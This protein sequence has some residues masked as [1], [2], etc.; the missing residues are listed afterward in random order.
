MTYPGLLKCGS[1]CILRRACR[2]LHMTGILRVTDPLMGSPAL[3]THQHTPTCSK[4]CT[5][6]HSPDA[7]SQRG[8]NVFFLY[9]SAVLWFFSR[10]R[11]H[12]LSTANTAQVHVN[13]VESEKFRQMS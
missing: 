6:S 10:K 1:S 7:G 5:G 2:K 4:H 8:M 12:W 9:F 11:S 3:L 13:L